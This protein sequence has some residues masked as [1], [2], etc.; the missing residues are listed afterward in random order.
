MQMH[1]NW[2]ALVKKR[3]SNDRKARRTRTRVRAHDGDGDNKIPITLKALGCLSLSVAAAHACTLACCRSARRAVVVRVR[4][5]MC[6]GYV[7]LIDELW[8]VH[9]IH[10]SASPLLVN[11]C[12]L[13]CL[14]LLN[15]LF[16]CSCIIQ[17]AINWY[18]CWLACLWAYW[19]SFCV[20]FILD[21]W[22]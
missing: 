6:D 16:A 1:R 13:F 15:I 8:A 20:S 19:M 17:P 7:L 18:S 14:S 11:L 9:V 3:E 10:V 2:R 12:A 5:C 4:M 22:R 21:V